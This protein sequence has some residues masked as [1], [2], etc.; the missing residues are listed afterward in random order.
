MYGLKPV[1]S[2]LKPESTKLKPLFS[3]LIPPSFVRS[4]WGCYS[5]GRVSDIGPLRDFIYGS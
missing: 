4:G 2:T 5:A 1:P 3:K